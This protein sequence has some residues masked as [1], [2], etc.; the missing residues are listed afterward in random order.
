MSVSA[1][2]KQRI[3]RYERILWGQDGDC[4]ANDVVSAIGEMVPKV[5][6]MEDEIA[7]LRLTD[8]EREALIVASI[9]LN[10]LH[11]WEENHSRTL[12]GLLERLA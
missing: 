10:T 11:C 12:R 8:A 1:E 6:A 9:E 2:L 7:R 3:E 4:G 5:E